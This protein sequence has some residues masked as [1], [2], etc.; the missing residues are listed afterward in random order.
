MSTL[1]INIPAKTYEYLVAK[2]NETGKSPEML[3]SELVEATYGI[4][5]GISQQSRNDDPQQV[6]KVLEQLGQARPLSEIL[7]AMI[8]PGVTLEEVIETLSQTPGPSL[9]QIVDEQRGPKI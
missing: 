6:R 4:R 7:R 5:N 3:A 2:A 9:G 1:V 8:I